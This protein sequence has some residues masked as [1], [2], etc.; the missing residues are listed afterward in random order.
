M[1]KQLKLFNQPSLNI[2]KKLKEKL[3]QSAKD[4]PLS[5]DELLDRINELAQRYGVRLLKGNGSHLT[6][7]TFEKWLNPDALDYIPGINSLVV[8]CAATGDLS[9]MQEALAP[10]DALLIDDT[11]AR[12]LLWA[13]EYHRAKDARTKMKKLEQQL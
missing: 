10:L 4:C 7:A 13:K 8:F 2:N 6:M 1:V 12:L 5:R 9:P 3:A 11:D